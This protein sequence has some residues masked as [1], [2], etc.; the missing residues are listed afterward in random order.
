MS[1]KKHNTYISQMGTEY[2]SPRKSFCFYPFRCTSNIVKTEQPF[3]SVATD[4][5]Y[6]HSVPL[7]GKS[8]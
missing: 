3:R 7:D 2:S 4:L 5:K 1:P 8:A 6:F